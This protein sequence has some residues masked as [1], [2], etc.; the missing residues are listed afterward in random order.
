MISPLVIDT[1][2]VLK[3][4]FSE[5]HSDLALKAIDHP[6]GIIVPD[7]IETQAAA[8]LWRRVRANEIRKDD[9]H[10]I[11]SNLRRLPLTRVSA[12]LLAPAALEIA[13]VTS[14]TFKESLYFAL[15]IQQ[16]TKLV[17][18]DRSWYT[19]LQTGPMKP[20]LRWIGD[21]SR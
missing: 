6:G 9:A 2:V 15:A 5:V 13:S 14:R 1:S 17:T 12:Q 4:Y 18:A 10:R 20:Y 11:L 3:W 16:N 21:L 7:T 19:L 8:A